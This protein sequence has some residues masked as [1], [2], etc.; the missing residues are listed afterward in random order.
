M[1]FLR[2]IKILIDLC[3][4]AALLLLMTCQVTG[5]RF[6]EWIGV[7]MFLLSV[8]H[9]ILNIRWYGSLLKGKYSP[10]RAVR[11]LINFAALIAMLCLAYSGMI[12]SRY[13]F[14][15]LPIES[16]MAL[17][18]V[19]HLAASYWGFV[20]MS[21]HLGFHWGVVAG[22]LCKLGEGKSRVLV[23]WIM[24]A[25]A[26]CFAGYGAFC[27]WQADIFSY[28]FLTTEFAFIDYEKNAALVLFQ[29]AAMA[30]LWVFIAY[31]M[32]KGMGN[33]S[34][35]SGKRKEKRDEEK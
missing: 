4:T 32:A 23:L 11:T 25:F 6:H 19:M 3:M 13:V 29:Y 12:L 14:A 34:A 26:L 9:N 35:V 15:A 8:I 33:F 30:G 28:M 7:F 27:F 31:Y 24:R 16:G 1:H 17:A 2:K 22:R 10:L 18:R 20:L 21:V 5:E